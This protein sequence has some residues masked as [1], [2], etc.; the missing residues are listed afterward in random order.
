MPPSL[1]NFDYI[2]RPYRWLEH[3]SFGPALESARFHFLNELGPRV[4]AL[5]LGDGDGRFSSK[6]MATNPDINVEAVDSSAT[7]L[8][9]LTR[10][11]ASLGPSAMRRLRTRHVDARRYH[12]VALSGFPHGERTTFDLVAT[13]F[14]LDCLTDAEVAALIARIRPNLAPGA[15][16]LVSEFAIPDHQP[17]AFL[18]STV[19]RCL[20]AA[21][22]FLTGLHVNRLPDY[23]SRM[24][25]AGFTLNNSKSYLGGLLVSQIWMLQG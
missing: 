16:W 5:V 25:R 17:A 11:V 24:H 18:S 7:M 14:F 3:L 20:Y 22:K 9:L 19:V 4:R 1:A 6:L 23:T 10:R 8:R 15:I 12:P 21:F 2:A 13:H